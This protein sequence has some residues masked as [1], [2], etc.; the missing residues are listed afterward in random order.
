MFFRS[1][2]NSALKNKC[3]GSIKL[4]NNHLIP[5]H[6]SG[7]DLQP[8][9]ENSSKIKS[10]LNIIDENLE[11]G[12]NFAFNSILDGIKCNDL[13][14]LNSNLENRFFREIEKY[15]QN[16]KNS[17]YKLEIL[18]KNIEPQVYF[19]EMSL[20]FGVRLERNSNP[21]NLLK[22]HINLSSPVKFLVYAPGSN[23]I[24][25]GL[26]VKPLL[27]IPI[28]F[29]TFNKLVLLKK[30][31]K[32]INQ[33]KEWEYHKV[34]F[35]KQGADLLGSLPQIMQIIDLS[36]QPVSEKDLKSV[37]HK[38]MFTK[39]TEWKITDFDDFMGGNEF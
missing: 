26:E 39:D 33:D 13:E 30:D 35:E 16:L 11:K 12:F 24:I 34:V 9:I 29:K 23:G 2:S 7:L 25:T 14:F 4:R 31:E 38:F 8:N 22:T 17:N 5:Y 6:F 27:Q 1:F 37:F 21:K 19:H 3:F 36:R 28:V 32:I 18:E 10:F 20:I 15:P